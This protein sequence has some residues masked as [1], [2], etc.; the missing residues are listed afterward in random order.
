MLD[1]ILISSRTESTRLPGICGSSVDRILCWGGPLT[2]S[3]VKMG[4]KSEGLV[5]SSSRDPVTSGDEDEPARIDIRALEAQVHD[6]RATVGPRGSIRGMSV[7]ASS[8][9]AQGPVGCQ[10][11]GMR[12]PRRGLRTGG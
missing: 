11:A 8:C 1:T 10:S 5:A 4:S 7:Y 3:T 12:E 6:I 9:E 2:K